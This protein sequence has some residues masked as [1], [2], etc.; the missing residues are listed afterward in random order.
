MVFLRKRVF[1]MSTLGDR[2][3][4]ARERKGFT[5]VQVRERTNINNKTLSGYEKGVSEPD[6]KTIVTLAE[7]YEV[8]YRWLISGQGQ[9]KE[10]ND[11]FANNPEHTEDDEFEDFIKDLRRWHKEDPKD[12][13]EDLAR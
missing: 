5:Q 6:T 7:L 12:K 4:L 2:L 3:R 1:L 11:S 9:I 10:Q 13:D 8:S